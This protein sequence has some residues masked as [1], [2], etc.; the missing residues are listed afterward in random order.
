MLPVLV[1]PVAVLSAPAVLP[2]VAPPLVVPVAVLSAPAVLPLVAP[3]LVVPP[4]VVPLL[5]PGEELSV[6]VE[7][8]PP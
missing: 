4:V 3:P 7:P 6:G 5:V 1:V 8:P 2:L